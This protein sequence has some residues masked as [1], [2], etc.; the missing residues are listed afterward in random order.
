MPKYLI[1]VYF[2]IMTVGASV[3]FTHEFMLE[4]ITREARDNYAHKLEN[5]NKLIF[6]G[7]NQ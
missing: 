3:F 7:R 5:C 1:V 4:R 2:F 6:Q